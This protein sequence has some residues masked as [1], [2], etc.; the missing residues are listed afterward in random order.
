M[1]PVRELT[2]SN[3]REWIEQEVQPKVR[4]D[5]G[6]IQ[7][8]RL[9]GGIIY[10]GAFADCAVCPAAAECLKWWLEKE[11]NRTFGGTHNIVIERHPNYWAL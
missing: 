1:S 8:K 3:L 9:E 2:E 7:F 11:V 5:G 10:L 6:E 4:V